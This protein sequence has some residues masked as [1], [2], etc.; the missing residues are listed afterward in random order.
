M[1]ARVYRVCVYRVCVYRVCVYR[2]RV[3]RVRV[4]RVRVYRVRVYR[5]RVY[6][7]RVYRVRVYR[8]RVYRVPVYRVRVYRVRVYRVRVY[9]VRVYRVCVVEQ[10]LKSGIPMS[11]IDSLISL[12][13]EGS[14]RLTHICSSHLSEYIYQLSTLKKRKRS[15]LKLSGRDVSVIFDGSTRLGEAL[16]I[17]LRFFSEGCIKQRLVKIAILNK[18]LSDEQL[19]RELLTALSTEVEIGGSLLLAAMHD[20]ASVNGVVMRTL[21]IM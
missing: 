4:Y 19:A 6:R 15:K 10:F 3:Y 16:G 11:K 18:S 8:V 2:V 1:D 13:E 14:H 9:R 7:V 21:S 17:V 20:H 12:L 5:V